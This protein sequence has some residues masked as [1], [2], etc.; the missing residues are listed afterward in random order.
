LTT[1]WLL[2][3]AP[4]ASPPCTSLL[5]TEDGG[6]SWRGIPAPRAPLSDDGETANVQHI[7][8]AD[9]L[10]GW[11]YGPSLWA[12]H[13]GGAHWEQPRLDGVDA[14]AEIS[15]LETVSGTVH[16]AVIDAGR[17]RIETSPT[18][19]DAWR[20]AILL[21][22]GAGPVPQAALV[23]QGGSGWVVVVNRT[24]IDGARLDHGQWTPWTPPCAS[25][26]GPAVVAASTPVD[27]VAACDEGLWTDDV[28]VERLYVSDD[29]GATFRFTSDRAPVGCCAQLAAPAAGTAM[30]NG[31]RDG[32]SASL[33]A[34]F[35]SGRTWSRV[36]TRP[37]PGSWTDLGFTSRDRGVAVVAEPAYRAGDL[38]MSD[39]GGRSW[40]VVTLSA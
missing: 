40:H 4:C 16:A 34:T 29:G 1:G 37:T 6:R 23:L 14:Q 7:R 38:V 25:A 2:G 5:R 39:D 19:A 10:N 3:T 9:A 36:Y 27:L 12:T 26:G 13:D 30:V 22:V 31:D 15:S 28:Q 11:V 21:E 20:S 18:G 17:V 35:D 33:L 32:R 8:F 24:V